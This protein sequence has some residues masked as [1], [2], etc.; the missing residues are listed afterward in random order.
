MDLVVPFCSFHLL[1]YCV[2]INKKSLFPQMNIQKSKLALSQG[3]RYPSRTFRGTE[4]HLALTGTMEK[5]VTS[6]MSSR[7]AAW[8]VCF[9]LTF[10]NHKIDPKHHRPSG[11]YNAI[12]TDKSEQRADILP[13]VGESF[14]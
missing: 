13:P 8:N 6:F 1:E 12:S 10:E 7:G 9:F 3:Q 2:W 4:G 14:G 5:F 11:T